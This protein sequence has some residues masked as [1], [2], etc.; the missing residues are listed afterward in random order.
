MVGSI[1]QDRLRK[2]MIIYT[3]Q[4]LL[5]W[6]DAIAEKMEAG[7]SALGFEICQGGRVA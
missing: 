6:P 4:L 7:D 2:S 3:P 5:D 1:T